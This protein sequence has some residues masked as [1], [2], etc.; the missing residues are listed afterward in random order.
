VAEQAFI[1]GEELLL[2]NRL[3]PVG[4]TAFPIGI[5]G[6]A[7][8]SGIRLIHKLRCYRSGSAL[9]VKKK[10]APRHPGPEHTHSGLEVGHSYPE[11][12]HSCPGFHD[13]DSGVFGS[14]HERA[15]GMQPGRMDQRKR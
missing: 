5:I 14:R 4:R 3:N 10:V 2:N 11:H 7:A 8:A 9:R 15:K 6:G 12:S 1:D 13:I